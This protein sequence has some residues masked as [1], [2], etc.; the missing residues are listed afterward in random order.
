MHFCS[1]QVYFKELK[2]KL[3]LQNLK[4]GVQRPH[5]QACS[6]KNSHYHIL[7]L[8]SNVLCCIWNQKREDRKKFEYFFIGS[9][10][11]SKALLKS[12]K[13][14]SGIIIFIHRSSPF[15]IVLVWLS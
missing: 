13:T 11:P 14:T 10:H 8:F 1:G 2:I 3:N 9:E 6:F 7:I 5:S 15:I 12:S 4:H